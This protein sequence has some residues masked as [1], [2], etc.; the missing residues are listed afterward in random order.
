MGRLLRRSWRNQ[1]PAAVYIG[2]FQTQALRYLRWFHNQTECT[3]VSNGEL[4]AQL[5]SAGFNNVSILE[6][7]VDS[8]LSTPQRRCNELRREWGVSDGDLVLVCVGRITAEK[9]LTLAEAYRAMRRLSDRIKLVIVGDGPLRSV[10]SRKIFRTNLRWE[11]TGEQLARYYASGDIFLFPSETE[12][13]QCNALKLE[14]DPQF[15]N[16]RWCISKQLG[17]RRP[18][19]AEGRA[20]YVGVAL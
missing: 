5:Q 7:R 14:E 10:L 2:R 12:L 16:S 1:L 19:R 18:A 9:N 11:H 6:R 17:L 4:R 15:I 3:L 8:Q 20:D 13:W